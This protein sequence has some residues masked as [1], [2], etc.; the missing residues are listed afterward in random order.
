MS[1]EGFFFVEILMLFKM[2]SGPDTFRLLLIEVSDEPAPP[3]A[4]NL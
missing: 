4:A 2:K 1:C 3:I